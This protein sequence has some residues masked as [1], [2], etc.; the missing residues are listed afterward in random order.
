M[1]LFIHAKSVR[2]RNEY[3]IFSA[4]HSSISMNLQI[5]PWGYVDGLVQYCSNSSA[6]IMELQQSYIKSPIQ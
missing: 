4:T 5:H 6:L 1:K 2:P 3:S